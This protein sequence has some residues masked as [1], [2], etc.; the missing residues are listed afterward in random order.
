MTLRELE[1]V[2]M[3][4]SPAEKTQILQW[5]AR[6]LTHTTPGISR[7]PDVMGGA[8]CIVRTRIPIWLLVHL[9]RQ[10][11]SEAD[12]LMNYPILRAEDLANAWVYAHQYAD[13]IETEIHAQAEA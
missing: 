11:M 9:R 4:L 1:S 7:Q 6:D 13:E 8:A 3:A 5:V 2:I 12:L 10:G